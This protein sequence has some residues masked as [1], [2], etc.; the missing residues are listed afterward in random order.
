MGLYIMNKLRIIYASTWGAI[1]AIGFATVITI[2]MEYSP[3]LKAWLVSLAGHHWTAKSWLTMIV[4]AVVA[5]IVYATH[6][7]PSDAQVRRS[8]IL[9]V[10]AAIIGALI[11]FGFFFFHYVG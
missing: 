4:Y 5:V 2:W 8:L 1:K 6:R 9:L 11:I 7:N 3:G 10:C